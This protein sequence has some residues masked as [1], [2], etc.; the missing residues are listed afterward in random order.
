MS[1]KRIFETLFVAAA[2]TGLVFVTAPAQSHA[3]ESVISASGTGSAGAQPDHAQVVVSIRNMSK[4]ASEAADKT[5]A[6]YKQ[7]VRAV[8]DVGV[9]RGEVSSMT[10]T[11]GPYYDRDPQGRQGKLAGFQAQHDLQIL[12]LQ[13]DQVGDVV[14]AVINAGVTNVRQVRFM[15]SVSDSVQDA[16]LGA[17]TER[18]RARAEIMAQALGGSLGDL[19]ELSTQGQVRPQPMESAMMSSYRSNDT[20][21]VPGEQR[22]SATVYGRWEFVK[23]KK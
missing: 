7:V 3:E 9:R 5:A 8:G 18:A 23:G 15:S 10:Y 6:M 22:F 16:A 4:T 1:F 14:D 19:V 21:I 12:V 11:F 13:L 2:I 17:A 20:E